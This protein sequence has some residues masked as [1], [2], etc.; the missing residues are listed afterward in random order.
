MPEKKTIEKARKDLKQGKSASTAAGEFVHEE[1]E[2]IRQGKHGA[3][4]AR[5]AIAI[6]LSKARRAGVPLRVPEAGQTSESTRRSAQR[7]TEVGQGK[8]KRR[9]SA[10]RSRA[11]SRRLKREPR[12]AASTT[13][14][15]RQAKAAAGRRRQSKKA[16]GTRAARPAAR[17]TQ[18]TPTRATQRTPTRATPQQSPARATARPR[19]RNQ[20]GVGGLLT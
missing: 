19:R 4:S 20:R 2:H 17:A 11:M 8:R 14:L 13:A 9:A 6:G 5:Q 1:I 10:K 12:T 3:R 16:A 18:R 7:D 15:S